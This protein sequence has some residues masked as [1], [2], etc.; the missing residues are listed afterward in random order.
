MRVAA[1]SAST[2]IKSVNR[3]LSAKFEVLRRDSHEETRVSFGIL[4]SWLR[5]KP[6]GVLHNYKA[7]SRRYP[8]FPVVYI[9]ILN[10]A[11]TNHP[12]ARSDLA[13]TAQD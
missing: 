9:T 11:P 6:R 8:V 12:K 10:L 7:L 3:F 13:P 4:V 5:I 2:A 1:R